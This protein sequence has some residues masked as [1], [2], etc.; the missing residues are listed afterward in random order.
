MLHKTGQTNKNS[1]N[2]AAQNRSSHPQHY[3]DQE[4]LKVLKQ[5]IEMDGSSIFGLL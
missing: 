5:N 4:G 3:L 1:K 2:N